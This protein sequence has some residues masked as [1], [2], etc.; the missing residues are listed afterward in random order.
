M[1][2]MSQ[3][4]MFWTMTHVPLWEIEVICC[5]MS[6]QMFPWRGTKMC[7]LLPLHLPAYTLPP[8]NADLGQGKEEAE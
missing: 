1:R 2:L 3:F 4:I 8:V 6:G 7:L 5:D